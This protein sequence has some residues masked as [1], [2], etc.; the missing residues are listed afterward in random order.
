MIRREAVFSEHHPVTSAAKVPS[1]PNGMAHPRREPKRF[2][3][4][5]YPIIQV[6]NRGPG[7]DPRRLFRRIHG[8]VIEICE[9]K[10]QERGLITFL[11]RRVRQ[12]FVVMAAAA[13]LRIVRGI[14]T[15]VLDRVLEDGHEGGVVGGVYIVENAGG[16]VLGVANQALFQA[17]IDI[18]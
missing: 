11:G 16:L 2:A 5:R 10:N 8:D 3:L 18:R 9:I 17:F 14:E 12:P 1:D 15:G 6:P 4:L 7:S 13:R